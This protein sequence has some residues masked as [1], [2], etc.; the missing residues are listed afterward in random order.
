MK[1]GLLLASIKSESLSDLRASRDKLEA[2]NKELTQKLEAALQA[3]KEAAENLS[4]FEKGLGSFPEEAITISQGVPG[5][6]GGLKAWTVSDLEGDLEKL[7]PKD[8]DVLAK[9]WEQ[10]L[11]TTKNDEL[12]RD[13]PAFI[14]KL[15]AKAS[16]PKGA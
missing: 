13:L 10:I 1:F 9:S 14:E 12:K 6:P 5:K 15:K 3:S 4:K 16:P 8:A 2:E 7:S 11:S